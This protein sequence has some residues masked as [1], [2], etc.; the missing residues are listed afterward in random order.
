[1]KRSP[2]KYIILL[3]LILCCLTACKKGVPRGVIPQGKMENL[4]YDYYL[5][6]TMVD[7]LKYDE[8]YKQVF[9]MNYVFDKHKV[10]QAQFDSSLVWYTRNAK[11]F[12][13]IHQHVS[14]RMKV[15][16]DGVNHLIAMRDKSSRD[17]QPGDTVNVWS[18]KKFHILT[19]SPLTNKLQFT[20]SPDTNYKERDMLVW[21]MDMNFISS[22]PDS[23]QYA[24]MS[25]QVKYANDTLL[26]D[27]RVAYHSGEYDLRIRYDSL[28]TIS[29]VRGFVYY[30]NMTDDPGKKLFLDNISLTRYHA[31]DTIPKLTA[32]TLGVD[33]LAVKEEVEVKE[34][35]P[36]P[37]TVVSDSVETPG[38]PA[39]VSPQEMRRRTRKE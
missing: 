6:K 15:Q 26:Y 14:E 25:M 18:D 16:R 9:Y 2:G 38:T 10:T 3:F 29:E 5:T 11:L 32:D 17:S 27:T 13:E 33:S 39:R 30:V 35:V 31:M 22:H 21:N 28:Y 24:V 37:D 8:R 4:L 12:A 34:I 23:V 19:G 36:A 1:M 7:D 20:I